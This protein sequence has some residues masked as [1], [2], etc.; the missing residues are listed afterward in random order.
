METTPDGMLNYWLG[1]WVKAQVECDL[2]VP[3]IPVP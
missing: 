1:Y 2:I 3:N